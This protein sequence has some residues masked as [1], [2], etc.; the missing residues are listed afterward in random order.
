MEELAAAKYTQEEIRQ[1][2]G[3]TT[4]EYMTLPILRTLSDNPDSFCY[5]CMD[6]KY[7]DE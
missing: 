5:A 2:T 3:A 1:M 4:L 6:G 7:W